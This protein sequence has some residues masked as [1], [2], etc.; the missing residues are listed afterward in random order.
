M[1]IEYEERFYKEILNIGKYIICIQF[2]YKS[3]IE[4]LFKDYSVVEYFK[5]Y[6]HIYFE[7]Y[8]K[9]LAKYVKYEAPVNKPQEK[10]V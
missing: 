6:D 2:P 9:N 8:D 5:K 7:Y 10:L 4:I 3:D 1:E